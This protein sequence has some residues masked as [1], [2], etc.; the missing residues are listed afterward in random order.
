MAYSVKNKQLPDNKNF[1]Y[2]GFNYVM[3]QRQ[4]KFIIVYEINKRA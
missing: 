3:R 2:T 1:Y 4:S